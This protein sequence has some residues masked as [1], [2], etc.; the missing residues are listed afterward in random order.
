M[1]GEF[2]RLLLMEFGRNNYRFFV[3][4]LL[5]EKAQDEVLCV[6]VIRIMMKSLLTRSNEELEKMENRLNEAMLISYKICRGFIPYLLCSFC[7]IILIHIFTSNNFITFLSATLI[8]LCLGIRLTQYV[9][10]KY[11]Y[12]DARLILSYKVSLDIVK[13]ITERK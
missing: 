5:N 6:P 7:T 8:A 4:Q 9:I 12:I 10:N 13:N 3:T 2:K 1:K 11:C